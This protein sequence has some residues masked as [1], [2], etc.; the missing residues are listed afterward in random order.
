MVVQAAIIS[1][2]D[3]G[4]WH[5]LFS[6]VRQ[7]I[8]DLSVNMLKYSVQAIID[9]CLSKSVGPIAFHLVQQR[10]AARTKTGM[11]HHARGPS[12]GS[13]RATDEEA[14]TN[15]NAIC[16]Q[17]KMRVYVYTAGEQVGAG[18]IDETC[19]RLVKPWPYLGYDTAIDQQIGAYRIGRGHD[20]SVLYE[21]PLH[22]TCARC[23]LFQ[24]FLPISRAKPSTSPSSTVVIVP[25]STI[26]LPWQITVVT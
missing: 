10:T 3:L 17:I 9:H 13:G 15:F 8:E 21:S 2:V 26:T 16:F 23:I 7:L 11:L 25:S 14:V 22:H 5:S 12:E 18:R 6:Q 4:A 20:D 24:S 1:Q 19:V